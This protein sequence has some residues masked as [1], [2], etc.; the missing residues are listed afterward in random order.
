MSDSTV[1]HQKITAAEKRVEALRLRHQGL[2]YAAIASEM[3]LSPTRARQLVVDAFRRL[4]ESRDEMA[5]E[6]LVREITDLGALKEA[7]WEAAMNGDVRSIEAAARIV[8]RI[9]KLTGLASPDR[10]EATV[11]GS[12]S[13]SKVVEEMTD[14][15]LKSQA[16]ALGLEVHHAGE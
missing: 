4:V 9:L 11:Q 2:S 8:E 1:S 5:E 7:A 13:L 12:V 14:E 10:V 3:G 6:I 15:E 16:E